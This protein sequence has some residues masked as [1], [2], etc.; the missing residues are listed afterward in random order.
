MDAVMM[1]GTVTNC[2][3]YV[4]EL[5]LLEVDE[6]TNEESS[7]G[8]HGNRTRSP[9]GNKFQSRFSR[10]PTSNHCPDFRILHDSEFQSRLRP[11]R[12]LQLHTVRPFAILLPTFSSP[13]RIAKI[14]IR[15]SSEGF[16]ESLAITSQVK[17]F[18]GLAESRITPVSLLMFR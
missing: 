2:D 1:T 15:L 7:I 8:K 16:P 3:R 18:S 10:W 13:M 11:M 9:L 4:D 14:C 5:E 12:K 6:R 17:F